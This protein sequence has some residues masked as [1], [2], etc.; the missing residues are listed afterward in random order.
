MVLNF[1]GAESVTLD[2]ATLDELGRRPRDLL[3]DQTVKLTSPM[4]VA[5][6]SS[7]VLAGESSRAPTAST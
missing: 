4:P 5:R 7:L 3:T 6:T 2:A 1:G